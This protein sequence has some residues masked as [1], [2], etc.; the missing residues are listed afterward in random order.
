MKTAKKTLLAFAVAMVCCIFS[1][2]AQVYVNV[3]PARPVIVRTVAPS[4]RHVWIDEDWIERDGT[5]IW[6]G[7]HW[8]EAREGYVYRPGRWAHEGRGH[9]WVT[10]RWEERREAREGRRGHR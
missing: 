6:A 5:Y 2:S 8:E 10:G 7:G 1:A 3:R 9:R 4:P